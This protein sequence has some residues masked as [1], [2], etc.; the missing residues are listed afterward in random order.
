MTPHRAHQEDDRPRPAQR[1]SAREALQRR[2][3]EGEAARAAKHQAHQAALC[4][5]AEREAAQREAAQRE[6]AQREAAQRRTAEEREATEREATAKRAEEVALIAKAKELDAERKHSA[7]VA[8]ARRLLDD[9]GD[10]EQRPT[11]A[12]IPK[13]VRHS[14]WQRDGGRCAECGSKE[15]LQ[16]D[17]LIP[18]SRGGAPNKTFKSSAVLVIEGRVQSSGEAPTAGRTETAPEQCGSTGSDFPTQSG[19]LALPAL[20]VARLHIVLSRKRG[21]RHDGACASGMDEKQARTHVIAT[22]LINL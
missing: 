11:R 8:W 20:G 13:S 17:H 16:Y 5:R 18:W 15:D 3:V 12:A 22:S 7:E 19:L 9:E 10:A 14:V 6:A 4:R 1:E 21:R 2:Q